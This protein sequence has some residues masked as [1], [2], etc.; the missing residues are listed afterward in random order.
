[1]ATEWNA[2][3]LAAQ[4]IRSI[5]GETF[6]VF[7]PKVRKRIAATAGRPAYTKTS[8]AFPGYLLVLW[9]GA[10]VW[11][12]IK[13]AEGVSQIL[14]RVGNSEAPAE[15]SPIFMLRLL[16]VASYL[17]VLEDQRSDPDRRP[18][19]PKGADVQVGGGL[20]HGIGGICEWSSEQRIALLMR[21]T[22]FRV[23]MRRDQVSVV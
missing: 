8:L 13:K 15:V 5:A 16:S 21:E 12:R 19:V 22:G 20:L 18:V 11:Q 14:H 4:S 6:Q 2:E 17:G 7:V 10:A 1:M 3:E 9:D 23:V